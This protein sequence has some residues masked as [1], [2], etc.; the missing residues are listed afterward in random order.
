MYKAEIPYIQIRDHAIN[1]IMQKQC[2]DLK[3]D[4]DTIMEAMKSQKKAEENVKY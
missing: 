2:N 4:Y 3:K 1:S